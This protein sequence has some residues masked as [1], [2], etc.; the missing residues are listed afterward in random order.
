MVRGV[1]GGRCVVK[2]D[3]THQY[4]I[5]L[6][7]GELYSRP[8]SFGGSWLANLGLGLGPGYSAP[9]PRPFVWNSHAEAEAH[10]QTLRQTAAGMG[11]ELLGVV[12]Q[13][14]CSP[15]FVTDPGPVG[16]FRR[17]MFAVSGCT[18]RHRWGAVGRRCGALVA[19]LEAWLDEGGDQ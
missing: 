6:P 4:A 14:V 1:A 19:E 5:A 7:N 12:V 13:R 8:E 17:Y 10:L 9:E 16:S 3:F 11:V 18:P 2:N 15:F